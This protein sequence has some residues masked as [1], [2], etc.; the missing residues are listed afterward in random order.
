[1]RA[2]SDPTVSVIIPT[3]NRAD[4]VLN[5]VESV[6]RQTYPAIE[7]I[8]VDDASDDSTKEALATLSGPFPVKILRNN[9]PR[10]A[11]ASRNI[12]I[13]HANGSFISGLDDD[14]LWDPERIRVLYEHFKAGFSA[15]TSYDRMIYGKKSRVWK[16]KREIAFEDLLYYNMAGNQ[17][18]TKKEY[19]IEA[20]GYDESLPAA[21]DYDLW[22][23]L[24]ERFGPIRTVPRVLQSVNAEEERDRIT[25]SENKVRGYRACLEKHRHKMNTSQI[26][27]QR[28]RL[29]LAE[30]HKAGWLELF[31]SAP[32]SLLKK[33]ITRK[34]F[35]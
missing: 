4:S 7:I 24:T 3:R 21:Q 5:A 26:R 13:E 32:L 35:L 20:G 28:Y 15:V 14:D 25:T 11:A 6:F 8:V 10:G 2:Q 9:T 23:R 30:G 12:A 19:I 1:M 29:K 22:I 34:L 33:E 16:K 31:R 27:Y 18:L 17:L